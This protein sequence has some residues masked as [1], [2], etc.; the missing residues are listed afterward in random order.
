MRDRRRLLVQ[1]VV[2]GVGFRPFVFRLA[3]S[4]HLAGSVR[5]LGDAGVEILIE[6][7]CETLNQFSARLQSELPTL[8]RI[9]SLVCEG[10]YPIEAGNG[11]R[12]E[13]LPSGGD[14]DVQRGSGSLP[15]D[16]AVCDACLAELLGSGSSRYRGYWATTCTDCGPR[17]TVIEDLPY[18]RPQTT[19][20]SFPMCAPCAAEYTNPADRRFHA[21]TIACP[22]CGPHL[23]WETWAWSADRVVAADEEA[24]HEA[25]QAL[26]GGRIV[27]IKGVG[28]TH[29]ACSARIPAAVSALRVRL[30]RPQQP[31]ALMACEADVKTIA[32]PTRREWAELRHPR[33]PIVLLRQASDLP[34]VIAPGL[35]TVGVMLPYSGLHHLLF[36]RAIGPLVMTS[37]NLPGRPM[38]IDNERIRQDLRGVADAALLHDRRIAH[39]CDDSVVRVVDDHP[40]LI[41]RSRGYVPLPIVPDT[42]CAGSRASRP[43]DG[44]CVLALGADSDVTIAVGDSHRAVASQYIGTVDNPETLSFLYAAIEHLLKLTGTTRVDAIACDLHPAFLTGQVGREL[45]ARFK[46]PLLRIQ[47]HEAHFVSVIAE[48]RL[49]EAIGIVLD[50]YGYGRDASAWG[51]ELFTCRERHIRRVGSLSPSPLPGGD[52]AAR[53]PLRVAA[54]YLEQTGST[55]ADVTTFLIDHGTGRSEAHVIA[56]QI[57]RRIHCPLTTSAGRFLDAVSA[58]LGVSCLRTYEGEPAMKLEAAAMQGTAMPLASGLTDDGG[59]ILIDAPSAFRELAG[60]AEQATIHHADLAASA[61][62]WLG[63]RFGE[64][65]T[66][67]AMR[68]GI[69]DVCLSGGVAV[70]EA[71]TRALRLSVEQAG[72]RFHVNEAVPCGDGG[73]SFGQLAWA[74]HFA[75][76]SQMP[77]C[78][79][80]SPPTER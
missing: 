27:A 69:R 66:R 74:L 18:D 45:S 10:G 42:R 48:H 64:A 41:R 78:M 79:S 40:R 60:H 62:G 11:A 20:D 47:H 38:Q 43:A 17:F 34:S 37:A 50:G 6:G 3:T 65:A 4:L 53:F 46:A 9:D 2:Q 36:D 57:T 54:G 22:R 19:M 21:Q 12:F 23:I 51:G 59:F 56:E 30:G 25:A 55:L 77:A 73:V 5:N 15:P 76:E 13:I 32:H 24:L 29:L 7:P 14:H 75:E 68:T 8:A 80:V 63:S 39:R 16:V 71:I 31:F 28:G 61:E 52:L 44:R 67:V 72:L 33:R 70:N 49:N 58:L 35:H 26:R 1:G